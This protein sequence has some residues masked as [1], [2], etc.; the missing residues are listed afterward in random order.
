MIDSDNKTDCHKKPVTGREVG[1]MERGWWG[2]LL[3]V[4]V[5]QPSVWGWVA[6]ADY[7]GQ[8]TVHHVDL[9]LWEFR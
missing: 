9:D 6:Q 7:K 3:S 1:E 4:G 2:A 5:V 8:K